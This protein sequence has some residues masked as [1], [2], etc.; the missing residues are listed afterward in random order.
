MLSNMLT[1]LTLF[2]SDHCNKPTKFSGS[3]QYTNKNTGI[4]T[5][6]KSFPIHKASAR[7]WIK[8]RESEAEY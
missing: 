1:V 8:F 3:S 2:I 5:H 6:L 4:S 7:G